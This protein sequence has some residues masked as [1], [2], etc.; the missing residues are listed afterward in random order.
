MYA[1]LGMTRGTTS[2]SFFNQ[3]EQ[4]WRD[5]VKR[6]GLSPLE[7]LKDADQTIDQDKLLL[8]DDWEKLAGAGSLSGS[9]RERADK[10]RQHMSIVAVPNVENLFIVPGTSKIR[11]K[12]G[13][14]SP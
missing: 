7:H 12:A 5:C 10:L 3:R 11:G 13:F 9:E 4:R 2:L 14:F 6:S 1:T 8:P